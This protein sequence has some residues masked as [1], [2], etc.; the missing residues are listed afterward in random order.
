MESWKCD[1]DN[2]C[3]DGSDEVDCQKEKTHCD[4]ASQFY[5]SADDRC[6]PSFLTCSGESANSDPAAA[7]V[8]FSQRHRYNHYYDVYF[9]IFAS[10][11]YFI[12]WGVKS[13][14]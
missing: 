3:L 4:D 9:S 5:C 2:D 11:E 8:H 10:D 14:H 6:I 1:N 12:V 13:P 7:A